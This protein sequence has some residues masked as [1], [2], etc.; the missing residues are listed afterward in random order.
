[1][2]NETLDHEIWVPAYKREDIEVS[3]HGRVRGT[4]KKKVLMTFK[5]EICTDILKCT[6]NAH[7]MHTKCTQKKRPARSKPN[8]FNCL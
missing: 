5:P 3:N 4:N 1:M 6:R 2:K 7:K 8:L